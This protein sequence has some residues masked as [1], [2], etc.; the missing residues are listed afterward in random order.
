MA[1]KNPDGLKITNQ[2]R[3]R[4]GFVYDLKCE[5]A[6]LTVSITQRQNPTDAGEWC[7]E[8]RPNPAP[9]AGP[10]AAWGATKI[11]ALRE[12]GRLWV[13]KATELGLPR[14][15][16]QAVATALTDVRAL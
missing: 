4:T 9:E 2:F 15:D 3:S 14:F 7:V 16:W 8:A 5:G 12:V 11:D 13:D 6:R 1:E 10:I